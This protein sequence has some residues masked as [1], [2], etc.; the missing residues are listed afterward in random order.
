MNEH[1]LLALLAQFTGAYLAANNPST[2]EL[3]AFQL[4]I[5]N[6]LLQ[7]QSAGEFQQSFLFETMQNLSTQHLNEKDIQHLN[8]VLQNA[9][10]SSTT[11]DSIRV[12]RR[13]VPFASSQVKG[14]VP[15]WA[16]GAKVDKTIG[17]LINAHGQQNWFDIYRIFTG[18]QLF[19]QGA[20]QPSVILSLQIPRFHF[21]FH[22]NTDYAIPASSTWINS[23]LI[24]AAAPDNQFCGLTVKSGTLHFT[25][26]VQL[27]NNTMIVP[28]GTTV[29]IT[30]ALVEQVDASVS[31]DDTG[32]DA[33]NAT[34]NLPLTFSFSFSDA[35]SQVLAAGDASWTVYQQEDN[36][37][38]D[39]NKPT[40]YLQQF[41]RVCIPYQSSAAQ[42]DTA[43][44]LSTVC[45]IKGTA[46]ILQSAWSLSCAVLDINNP[47]EAKGIG[48]MMIQT[49]KGLS[50][51]WYG[52]QDVNLKNKE[53]ISLRSPWI[54]AEPGRI[55]I[56]DLNAGNINA[57]QEY[58]LWKNDKG[59]WNTIDLQY[60]ESFLFFYNCLQSG[61]EAVMAFANCT[62]TID[63]P[64]DVAGKPFAFNS[65]QTVFCLTGR[66]HCSWLYCMMITFLLITAALLVP[67]KLLHFNRRLLH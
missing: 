34:V 53:W 9:Q 17:P 11:G 18:V 40:F 55:S 23:H 29:T 30:L 43:N 25:N 61:N 33:K 15:D 21:F 41:N 13:E 56:T 39:N 49:D 67:D 42:F 54:L 57:K 48:A 46:S 51:S 52:L 5:A 28:P 22:N 45:N 20:A 38:L 66:R 35:G 16:R 64:V 60:T 2:D 14:S 32:I 27:N 3:H 31:P 6:A 37:T 44:C 4:N 63:R 10:E 12:F 62:G 24:S 26:D 1:P 65:K 7:K 19:L 50:A 58:K 47:L 59:Q 36:F 8:S